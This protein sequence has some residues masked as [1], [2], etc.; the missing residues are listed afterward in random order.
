MNA[1]MNEKEYVP[2]LVSI[3]I[4]AYK[5]KWLKEAIDSA[6]S[7]DYPNIEVIIVDDHSP[8]NLKEVVTPFLIDKRVSYYYN[9]I[10]LG[11]K[12]VANNWN[13]CLE[14]VRGEFFVLLCD[15][16]LLMPNFVSELLKLV[17]K[18]PN[19]NIFHGGRILYYEKTD[20]LEIMDAW[21]EY[22]SFTAFQKEKKK[23]KRKHTITEFLYR[24]SCIKEKK[25]TVFPV[26]YFS[27]DASILEVV[28]TGGI[29]SSQTPLV[30][31]RISSD[32]ISSEGKFPVEKA[33][34]AI[35]YYE[36]YG[37]NPKL[38]ISHKELKDSLDD[39]A[40]RCFKTASIINKIRILYLVPN[41]VWPLKQ[42]IF[43]F[44]K[45]CIGD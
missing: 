12:S 22:E 7:Q 27:D 35:M 20:S 36:W 30:R 26:G 39:W 19:C 45:A 15:D 44:I 16:D 28:A 5:K 31:I 8:Q 13:K 21:P 2:G 41:F 42:K 37:H 11:G 32:Q 33:K 38:E 9:E 17:N 1:I 4:P 34:A 10:N 29:V 14:Y 3:A 24:S 43:L 23:V 25:Y 6:L 40:Y 18:Y